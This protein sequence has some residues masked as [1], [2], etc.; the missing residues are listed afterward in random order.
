LNAIIDTKTNTLIVGCKNTVIPTSVTSIGSFAFSNC[1]SLTN[2][3]IPTS[4]TS[5]ESFAFNN[6]SS[7]T[8][9]EI[10][11]SVTSIEDYAFNHCS[12]LSAIY[13]ASPTPVD[14][15]GSGYIFNI[16]DKTACVLYVPEG[17]MEAYQNAYL[18]KD[19][20][21]IKTFVPTFVKDELLPDIVLSAS[22]MVFA[23]R[24]HVGN[25]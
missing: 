16:V 17:S 6:C 1:S 9:I 2:I 22:K 25:R 24:C 5:I 3:E 4:V 20:Q 13:A 19:F 18:W 23:L 7:L 14:L 15:S 8:N 11:T 21:T 10:P 12:G